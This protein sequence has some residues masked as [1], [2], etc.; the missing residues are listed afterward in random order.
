M[1]RR[2]LFRLAAVVLALAG[3]LFVLEVVLQMASVAFDQADRSKGRVPVE[4][5]IRIS[6]V[7]ESTTF[8]KWPGQLEEIL[9]QRQNSRDIRV[10]NRGV[11]G[12]RTDDVAKEIEQWLDEDQPHL[13]ITMLGINDEGNVLVYPRGDARPWLLKHLRTPRLLGLLW[14]SAF[15][16]GVP[17]EKN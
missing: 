5:E 11:V 12:I 6:C 8:G 13:V 3:T 4:G 10:I 17:T 1:V 15:D 9:N 14:R 16:I 7:G 2:V